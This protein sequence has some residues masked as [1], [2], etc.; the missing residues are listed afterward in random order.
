MVPVWLWVGAWLMN[1]EGGLTAAGGGTMATDTGEI[2]G[3]N[4]LR[5][6]LCLLDKETKESTAKFFLTQNVLVCF[7]EKY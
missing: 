7:P 5:A 1:R 4:Q 3:A 6:E 2:H